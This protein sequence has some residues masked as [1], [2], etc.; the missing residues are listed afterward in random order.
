MLGLTYAIEK[1]V[2]SAGFGMSE[3]EAHAAVLRELDGVGAYMERPGVLLCDRDDGMLS[4]LRACES[5][6]GCACARP[7]CWRILR[8]GVIL[9]A[10]FYNHGVKGPLALAAGIGADGLH[11]I[12][13]D[14]L[15]FLN[16][17]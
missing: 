12:A 17:R 1:G 5:R 16:G 14:G 10:K 4:L 15:W 9:A 8:G 3:D 11:V 6:C 13:H 2:L 7:S